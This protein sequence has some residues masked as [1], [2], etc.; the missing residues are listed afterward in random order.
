METRLLKVPLVSRA[1]PHLNIPQGIEGGHSQ[2]LGQGLVVSSYKNANFGMLF[3]VW[4][5]QDFPIT[6]ILREINFGECKN[7]KNAIFAILEA[8]NF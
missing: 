5:F 3:T 1:I 6:Q 8:L 2:T 7:S 4:K